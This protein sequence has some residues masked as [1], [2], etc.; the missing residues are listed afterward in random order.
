MKRITVFGLVTFAAAAALLAAESSPKDAITDAAA[1]LAQQATIAGKPQLNS[2]TSPA[3][4]RAKAKR[5][6]WWGSP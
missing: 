6:A 5:T 1:K 2:G 3:H 4:P